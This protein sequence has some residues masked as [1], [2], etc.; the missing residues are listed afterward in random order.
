MIVIDPGHGGN[1][2]GAVSG[3]T[4]EKDINLSIAK[5]VY[6]HLKYN[7]LSA[8]LTRSTDKY[9]SL[10]ER[11]KIAN[12]A[13]AILFLSIHVNSASSTS[14]NGIETLIYSNNVANKNVGNAIHKPVISATKAND[15]GL[16]V[17]SDLYVLKHTSMKACLIETGFISN[18]AERSK[19]VLDSYQSTLAKSIAQ[20]ICNY[21]AVDFKEPS[22][23]L[24]TV[25]VGAYS[26]RNNAA[27]MAERLKAAGYD[28]LIVTK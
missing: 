23:T 15:R 19:L 18:A 27:N 3:T 11:C 10:K 21:F 12:D 6:E 7:N 2:P 8:K 25:Q 9:I 26:D 5:K 17:R 13:N 20:G 14:A 28:T 1:D 24:Y 16:K 4:C 22:D